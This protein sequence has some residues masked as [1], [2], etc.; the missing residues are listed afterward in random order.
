M[1]TDSNLFRASHRFARMSPQKA[2][3]VMDLIR[4]KPVEQAITTLRFSQ[5]RASP[6]ISKVLKSAMANATQKAGVE[7]SELV[8]WRAYVDE[9]PREKRWK[10]RSMGRAYTRLRRRCH[11]SV[12]LKHEPASKEKEPKEKETARKAGPQ[13]EA[14]VV[15]KQKEGAKQAP[16]KTGK[17]RAA[18]GKAPAEEK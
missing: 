2:R 11:L 18:G 10:T 17:K 16:G 4:G 3:L 14:A 8:V 7:G 9:G 12:I 13:D 1:A 6:M 5:R 15:K